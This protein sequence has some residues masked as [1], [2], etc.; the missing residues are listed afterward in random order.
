MFERAALKSRYFVC[1]DIVVDNTG[2][3]FTV[4]QDA[5]KSY[6]GSLPEYHSQ[7]AQFLYSSLP[8][9]KVANPTGYNGAIT[10]WRT[11][12]S[13]LTSKGLIGDDKL[14]LH[15][16]EDLRESLRWNKIGRPSSLG[17]VVAELDLKGEYV[18]LKQFLRGHNEP[19]SQWSVLSVVTRPLAWAASKVLGSSSSASSEQIDDKEWRT[20]QGEWV[21]VPLVEKAAAVVTPKLKDLGYDAI[22]R[23]YTVK[24]FQAT[25][26]TSCFPGVSLSEQDCRVLAKHL[27]TRGLCV[28]D[29]D[30][31][32]LA[33]PQAVATSASTAMQVTESDRGIL[34]L[35]TTLHSLENH[36]SSIESRIESEQSQVVSYNNKKQ[37]NMAKHHLIARKRLE[38]LLAQRVASK[39]KIN[40][41]L[42]GIEKAVGDEQTMQALELGTET[43]RTLISS[44]H[45]SL[46]HIEET[47]S[48][49]SDALADAGEINEAVSQVGQLDSTMEDEVNAELKELVE[50]AERE[51]QKQEDEAELARRQREADSSSKAVSTGGMSDDE[52]IQRAREIEKQQK[53]T[54]ED[55]A[56]REQ[57]TR[58]ALSADSAPSHQPSV[59]QDEGESVAS[60][61]KGK[62]LVS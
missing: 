50:E 31:I 13:T 32:K 20:R 14:V 27:S 19:D 18:P 41:V 10:W 5:L 9:R 22:S 61:E 48:A 62:V 3:I 38:A 21:I 7:R 59:K 49:L 28:V 24:S 42:M 16:D 53:A 45:L 26:G 23:L 39:D 44:P 12:L 33:P 11:T 30:V 58:D 34:T 29:D 36:I 8:A 52:H 54:T 2:R 15:V 55:E 43:L 60:L 4:D 57:A 35:K 6:L 47:T 51:R 25:I 37:M 17:A 40:E 1:D 56:S 46:D